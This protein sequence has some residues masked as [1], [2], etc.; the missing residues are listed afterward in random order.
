MSYT[1]QTWTDGAAGGT[2]VNAARL[3]YIEAGVNSASAWQDW[4]DCFY[5]V[6]S[7]ATIPVANA[8]NVRL[9][10]STAVHTHPDITP[11]ADFTTFT[12]NRTGLWLVTLGLRFIAQTNGALRFVTSLMDTNGLI[13]GQQDISNVASQPIDLTL[14]GLPVRLN[15]GTAIVN[16]VFHNYGSSVNIDTSAGAT[17]RNFLSAVFIRP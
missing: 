16:N 3:N 13:Y 6:T 7:G 1:K 8:A 15:A 9:P 12:V 2:P 11:S 17:S 4:G 10:C 14:G 5:T